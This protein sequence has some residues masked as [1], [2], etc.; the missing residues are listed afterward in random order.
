LMNE[1]LINPEN[2]T[3]QCR[4]RFIILKTTKL[5]VSDAYWANF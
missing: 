4:G 1:T 2:D 3:G 5:R